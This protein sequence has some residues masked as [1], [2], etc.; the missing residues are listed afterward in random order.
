MEGVEEEALSQ[1]IEKQNALN[2]LETSTSTRQTAPKRQ[3]WRRGGDTHTHT[4]KQYP[5]LISPSNSIV[6]SLFPSPSVSLSL[7]SEDIEWVIYEPRCLSEEF[8]TTATDPS[9]L[10]DQLSLIRLT[11]SAE[12]NT[13]GCITQQY[14][15][16]HSPL[17]WATELVI[18]C[19]CT[20]NNS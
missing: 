11:N 17:S 9:S 20:H 7:L 19:S 16:I 12:K 10:M 15:A 5:P 18:Y 2:H 1:M 6:L 8:C 14:P 3:R 4:L 13:L